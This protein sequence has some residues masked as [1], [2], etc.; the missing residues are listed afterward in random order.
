MKFSIALLCLL[1]PFATSAAPVKVKYSYPNQ[2]KTAFL[3]S[4]VGAYK[5]MI[6]PCK[7]MLI[8]FQNS[9]PFEEFVALAKSPDPVVD[10]RFSKVSRNCVAPKKR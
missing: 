5:E 7:C 6:E 8:G 2:D 1:I 9:L 4:C 3:T 10:P